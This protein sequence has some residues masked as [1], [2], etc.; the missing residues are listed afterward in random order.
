MYSMYLLSFYVIVS[1]GANFVMDVTALTIG[2]F[3]QPSVARNLIE[4]QA[5]VEKGLFQH[6]LWIFPQPSYGHFRTL[7]KPDEAFS[8]SLG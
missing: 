8:H 5:S 2:G 6:F 7:E 1:E 3:T 4:L